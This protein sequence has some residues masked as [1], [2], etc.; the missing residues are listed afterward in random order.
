MKTLEIFLSYECRRRRIR[1]PKSELVRK[2]LHAYY[3]VLDE[4]ASRSEPA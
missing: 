2:S 3:T 4:P 1:N